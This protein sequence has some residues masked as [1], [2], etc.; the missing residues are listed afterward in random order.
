MKL[1]FFLPKP[2]GALP[3]TPAVSVRRKGQLSLN[4]A[5]T[6]AIGAEPGESATICYDEE[7]EQWLLAHWPNGQ[8]GQPQLN[9]QSG[10][11]KGLRFQC[12]AAATPLFEKVLGDVATLSCPLDTTAL[13]SDEAPGASLYV[14]TIPEH[15]FN[16]STLVGA[17]PALRAATKQPGVGPG[18]YNR[19]ASK[20]GAT[21]G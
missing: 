18:N 12:L 16:A 20:K 8:D 5:A 3:A 19:S 14:L 1:K 13:K 9:A 17:T 4:I 7:G 2:K 15:Y 21:R 10:K 6:E 11:N